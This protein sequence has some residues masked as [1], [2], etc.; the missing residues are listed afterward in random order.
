MVPSKKKAASAA[1][2]V[3]KLKPLVSPT[4]SIINFMKQTEGSHLQLTEKR[5][6]EVEDAIVSRNALLK[7]S[8]DVT[9]IENQSGYIQRA[10]DV[11]GSCSPTMENLDLYLQTAI[12]IDNLKKKTFSEGQSEQR[13]IALQVNVANAQH[14]D[15]SQG[16]ASNVVEIGAAQA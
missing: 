3:G 5:M 12:L 2:N 6:V 4:E 8:V 14:L 16:E 1:S 13:A 9:H 7:A 15:P 11:L 10:H